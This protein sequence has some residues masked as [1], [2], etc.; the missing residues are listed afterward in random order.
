M[1]EKDERRDAF[2]K[3][4]FNVYLPPELVRELKHAAID[5][6][7]SLS[8]YVERIFREFLDRKREEDSK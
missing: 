2:G 3:Q 4:Q 6:R 1:D 7:H 8:R 5:D